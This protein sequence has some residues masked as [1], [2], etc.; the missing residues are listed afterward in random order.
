MR[1]DR[2]LLAADVGATKCWLALLPVRGPASALKLVRR[3]Q[4]RDY[5]SFEALL[6]DYLRQAR[7]SLGPISLAGAVFAAAGPV[8]GERVRLTNRAWQLDSRALAARLGAARGTIVND[9]AAAARGT[10]LLGPEDLETLQAGEPDPAA[11]RV[12]IGAG[13]GLGVAYLVRSGPR[14]E[15]I[16]G[17]AGHMGF[18]PANA[19]QAALWSYLHARR[20]RVSAEDVLSGPGLAAIHHFLGG[21]NDVS[22]K[23]VDPAAVQRAAEAGDPVA[24]RALDLFVEIYGAVA[25]DHA[26]ALLARGGVY[27]AGGIAPRIRQRLRSGRFVSAFNDKREHARL[28]HRMPVHVV[29]NDQLSLLGAATIALDLGQE[30]CG[31]GR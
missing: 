15:A 2:L 22:G 12:V 4:D 7:A 1:E 11:P 9:F 25:G 3:Y 10:L 8:S 18:S 23:E 29:I 27:V 14:L 28:A 30:D 16:A 5:A 6:D 20:G 21:G 26:L 13:T 19:E 17:E 24:S 31:G